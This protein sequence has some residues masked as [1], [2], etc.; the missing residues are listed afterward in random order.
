MQQ[1]VRDGLLVLGR[2]ILREILG[3]TGGLGQAP[4]SGAM[5]ERGRAVGLTCLS[6]MGRLGVV[7]S[8]GRRVVSIGLSMMGRLRVVRSRG[9]RV[10]SIAGGVLGR[11]IAA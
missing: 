8:G 6:K 7:R 10:G 1:I 9:R 11:H 3:C 5:G 2:R 4:R